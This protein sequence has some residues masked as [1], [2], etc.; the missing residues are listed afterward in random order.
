MPTLIKTLRFSVPAFFV[1]LSLFASAHAANPP[2]AILPMDNI[3]DPGHISTPW[4][5]CTPTD[6]NCYVTNIGGPGI[7]SYLEVYGT[8]TL[9]GTTTMG[10]TTADALDVSG[11]ATT[12]GL[13]FTNATGS[14]ATITNISASDGDITNITWTN[15]TG[16]NATT[17]NFFSSVLR[18]LTST[19]TNL[20]WTNATG[21]NL[22]ATNASFTG[23]STTNLF[24]IRASI[25][26]A[27][28]TN[29]F[30][31]NASLTNATSVN[32]FANRATTT[33]LVFTNATGTNATITN[34]A[35]TDLDSGNASITGVATTSGLV[36]T[37]ATGTNA[38]IT[39]LYAA[40]ASLTN[41]TT[42][43]FFA[44][45]LNALRATLT[46]LLFG[47][48]TGTNA[49]TT[50]FAAVDADITDITWTNA[51]G[52][53]TTSTNL[54]AQNLNAQNATATNFGVTATI[55]TVGLDAVFGDFITALI[56]GLTAYTGNFGTINATS[57]IVT[58][59][60]T[61][62]DG[63]F[64][65]LVATTSFVSTNAIIGSTTVGTIVATTSMQTNG[66]FT[67]VGT[68]TLATT[69]LVGPV[70]LSPFH[71]AM[72]RLLFPNALG[73]VTQDNA[74]FWNETT[75]SLGLGTLTP[76]AM[77]DIT[78]GTLG[79]GG[80]PAFKITSDWNSGADTFKAITVDVT[81][82]ASGAA[83]KLLELMVGG[84][85]RF[86]VD[87]FGNVVAGND[88]SVVGDATING[89]LDMSSNKIVNLLTPT[90]GNDAV[91]KS[92]VDSLLFG[93]SWLEPV[94]DI[95]SSS[96]PGAPS[97]GDRYL[98]QSGQSG[99]GLCADDDIA[100][101]NGASWT[102]FTPVDGNT[103]YA[104][105]TT[106]TQFTYNGTMW[107][108]IGSQI[109]HA[110]LSNLQGGTGGEYY[111]V[112]AAQH[113][114]LN[115]VAAQLGQLLTTGS[116][117]F[118]DL[119]LNNGE[120]RTGDGAAATPSHSFVNDA[121]TGMYRAGNDQIGFSTAGV[122]RAV[123]DAN[124]RLGIGNATPAFPLDVVGDG[125][126]TGN[127]YAQNLFATGTVTFDSLSP[128][129]LV[130]TDGTGALT[131]SITSADTALSV[132]DETGT[133]ALVFGTSP[134]L[135]TPNLGTPSA[136]TL[137]NATGLPVS[138]GI[139]GLAAG[140]AT[141]L[142]TPSSANLIAA[143]TDETGT[144]AL[145]F[146]TAPTITNATLVNPDLG[147]PSSLTLTNATGLPL[148][149]GV[150]G[151]LPVGN[152]GTGATTFVNNRV[153]TGNGAGALVDEANLTFDGSTLTIGS[154]ASFTTATT[155]FSSTGGINL[156]GGGCFAVAGTCL[157]SGGS[158]N[159]MQNGNTFA[160]VLT[161]G[162]NDANDFVLETSGTERV[163]ITAAGVV[164]VANLTPDRLV[165]T[166][167]GGV[168][169]TTISSANLALS[170]SDETGTGALVFG[171]SPTFTTPNL[172][173]P[174]TL[175]LANATALPL[176]TGVSGTLP[177]G[178]GGTGATTFVNNRL[179]TGN[180]A[181]AL[182]DE[183]NLTFD[184]ST[185]TIGSIASFTTAS[186]TFIS[187]GG[188]NLTGGGCFAISGTCIS[189]GGGGGDV[190]NNGNSYGALMTLGTNDA[191][192]LAFETGG[193]EYMRI[194]TNGNVGIN[195]ASPTY[196]L[197][198]TGNIGINDILF[199][200]NAG[201][202]ASI[203]DVSGNAAL[204]LGGAG[205][206]V[207]YYN[208]T[209]HNFRNRA[210]TDY[211]IFTLDGSADLSLDVEGN[212]FYLQD[213]NLLA[214]AGG[215]CGFSL[216][217]TGNIGVEG[218]IG[219]GVDPSNGLTLAA[220]KA[221]LVQENTQA[222]GAAINVDWRNGNQQLLDN[223]AGATTITFT[224]FAAGQKLVLVICNPAGGAG[225]AV[226]WGTSI[227][228]P[229]GTVPT[230]TTTAGKCDAYSF[231]ATNAYSSLQVFGA[232]NANF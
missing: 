187:T 172:G 21:T 107:V 41:A 134:T 75:N 145:V 12:S 151:T 147:T 186:T 104:N 140:V 32:L 130:A 158:G 198:V 221:I 218:R 22:F 152:G 103:V 27:T 50:N 59:I 28:T 56:A 176:A 39:N 86:T 48:A 74:L 115:S 88:L 135:T 106:N 23:A 44:A 66:S 43:N 136:V 220:G 78:Q 214:C 179:L 29:L 156:T 182:V 175:N 26:S 162:T 24:A 129:R 200:N 208:N 227:K 25:T 164:S 18:A 45:A 139:S 73:Q 210:G 93:L 138:T 97:V 230:Q 20:V 181:G 193:T 188:L 65:D 47:N 153:L 91:N 197:D 165:T 100:T 211:A 90:S 10:T 170:V 64:G 155:T 123:I 60:I 159:I 58:P 83:S 8:S 126:F 31:A 3:Q 137:T 157:S 76:G 81:D 85:P 154:V 232:Q 62:G 231:L 150:T 54:Y 163:R 125:F 49:T 224:N 168:L 52:T 108:S 15:A 146:G 178:N 177:V 68:S 53:N 94:F 118:V 169:T 80:S 16:T 9:T 92:Y 87:K 121:D 55:T 161:L 149:T 61:S 71:Y 110:S 223:D 19:L 101:W 173:T 40:N 46:D 167:A 190:V 195:D 215:A 13:V 51:T 95:S 166:T 37:N 124:G 116:P 216:T 99:F 84:V 222:D 1:F 133:G 148:T 105:N 196:D 72:G 35:A 185:L 7:F 212:D 2:A 30:A 69:T 33:N 213:E 109:D 98:L 5:G 70:T 207:N 112:T 203:Y 17:T 219:V 192:A 217:G 189:G 63:V 201:N 225:G 82:T 120:L 171:T 67:A 160:A 191:N 209:S 184:G 36:F 205:D 229:G 117:T 142:A 42:T 141:V 38:T 183:A 204:N 199:A 113:G 6:S 226:S 96:A 11:T 127:V 128:N 174:S 14:N 180:G 114:N 122:L 194:L 143:V 228:W 4:G 111:H 132:T 202:Y 131:N 77:L 102:C 206:P 89:Q 144:G 57:S 34:L 119:T 79:A